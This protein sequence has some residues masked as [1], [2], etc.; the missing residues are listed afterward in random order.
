[1]KRFNGIVCVL[2]AALV[3]CSITFQPL[4]SAAETGAARI[5]T[6]A[7]GV[8]LRS[9]PEVND[10]NKIRGVHA[11]TELDV[12]DQVGEWF[13]VYYKGDWGYVVNDPRY[14]TVIR[15]KNAD[16]DSW[17]YSSSWDTPSEDE[18]TDVVRVRTGEQGVSLRSSP[19]KTDDNKIRGI[20]SYT[21]VDVYGEVNGW[22][23]VYYKGDWGYIANDPRYVTVI[24][25]K[26]TDPGYTDYGNTGESS[27]WYPQPTERSSAYIGHSFRINVDSGRGRSGP[28]QEYAY[29]ETVH[30]GDIYTI[31]DVAYASNGNAWY[32]LHVSGRDCWVASSLGLI[33]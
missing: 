26:N 9:S 15:W 27:A 31:L 23:Y 19:E 5:R 22:F 32:K 1:M 28:G 2:V 25:R 6:G 33:K 3:L 29:I 21:E 14:V 20:H 16:E 8:S 17:D 11:N 24:Q 7:Q 30:Y 12:Y 4:N 10:E 18:G 13:Y